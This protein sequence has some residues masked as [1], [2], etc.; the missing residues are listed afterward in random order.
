MLHV[1]FKYVCNTFVDIIPLSWAILRVPAGVGLGQWGLT[2]GSQVIAR[3]RGRRLGCLWL[4][5]VF[6]IGSSRVF[7]GPPTPA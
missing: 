6:V 2:L 1:F 4:P 3:P 7:L 5:V